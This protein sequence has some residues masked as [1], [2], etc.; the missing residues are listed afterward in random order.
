MP[1]ILSV[2]ERWYPVGG[3]HGMERRPVTAV[4]VEGHMGD[5]AVYVGV[6]DKDH[7]EDIADYGDKISF[8]EAVCH[9]PFGL[10]KEKYRT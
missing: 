6:G 3:T 5:Y 8:G 10:E 9:F 2:N 7:A 1:R 4:L